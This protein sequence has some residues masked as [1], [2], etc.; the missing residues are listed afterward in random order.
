MN[1]SKNHLS[2]KTQAENGGAAFQQ[3]HAKESLAQKSLAQKSQVATVSKTRTTG[4]L[5]ET[6]AARYFLQ[7]GF[8]LLEKNFHVQGGEIDLIV[9]K[10]STLFF[11]EVKTRTSNS[12][13]AG[14]QAFNFHKRQKLLRAIFQYL[15]QKSPLHAR[16][17]LDFVSIQL[18]QKSKKAKL[19]HFSDILGA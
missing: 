1:K 12:F 14:E 16:W 15:H 5:G 7:K 17:Q 9:Q 4:L 2:Q 6:L 3:S 10:D 8:K 11:V 19:K 18:D 13:G